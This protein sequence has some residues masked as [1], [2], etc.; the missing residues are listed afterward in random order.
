MT[1]RALITGVTGQDGALLAS[2]LLS[3]GYTV[4]GGVRRNS[5]GNDWRLHELKVLRHEN[6]HLGALDV[7]DPAS[8]IRAIHDAHPNEIYNLAAQSFVGASFTQPEATTQATGVGVLNM[9]EAMRHVAPGA[10]F[11]QASSSEIFGQV[12]QSPQDEQTEINPRSP[13]GA[14]K[15]YGHYT[16]RIYR[17][18]YKLFVASGVL[19]NHESTLRGKEFVTR[20]ITSQLGQLAVHGKQAEPLRLGNVKAFRD[21]GAAPDYVHGMWRMLQH[22][23]PAEF[24]LATGVSHTVEEFLLMACEAAGFEPIKTPDGKYIN[25]SDE[26]VLAT[27][28]ES[29]FRPAEVEQL[30]GNWTKAFTILHWQPE[31][32]LPQLIEQ[33]VAKDIDRARTAFPF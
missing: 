15:A 13:Y 22:P 7:T 33:M 19:F 4:F 25:K 31:I 16:A 8:C 29:Q 6:F 10:R 11:Y 24:V 3:M 14:A 17:D 5:T 20:K 27:I 2:F 12:L 26:L 30:K 18:A 32:G 28:D 9:L 23:Y 21:W 1:K